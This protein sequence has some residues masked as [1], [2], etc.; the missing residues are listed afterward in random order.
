MYGSAWNSGMAYPASAGR[1][2]RRVAAPHAGRAGPAAAIF[3]QLEGHRVADEQLVEGTPGRVGAVEEDLAAVLVADEPVALSRVD[4][5][6]LT[7]RRPS[8]GRKRLIGLAGKSGHRGPLGHMIPFGGQQAV[9]VARSAP[10][11]CR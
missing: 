9:A 8:G 6:D 7:A 2:A 4:A 11:E 10:R 5:H 3:D 1:S